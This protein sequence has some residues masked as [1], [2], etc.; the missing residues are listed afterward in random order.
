[1]INIH[2]IQNKTQLQQLESQGEVVV[3]EN[4]ISPDQHTGINRA[5]I[6]L[7][8]INSFR[9]KKIDLILGV[10]P[11][12]NEGEVIHSNMTKPYEFLLSAKDN[13][14]DPNTGEIL[15]PDENGEYPEGSIT[16]YEFFRYLVR[17]SN[18]NIFDL[19]KQSIINSKYFKLEE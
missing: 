17:N 16:E 18:A 1:M 11:L 13:M 12:N 15:D 2:N 6:V 14:V 9:Q 19:Y 4:E 8:N 3:Y 10:L 7:D 5:I